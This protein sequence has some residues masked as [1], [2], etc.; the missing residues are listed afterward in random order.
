MVNITLQVSNLRRKKVPG[1]HCTGRRVGPRAIL[2]GSNTTKIFFLPEKKN[3]IP[4]C[5]ARSAVRIATALPSASVS[6]YITAVMHNV[7]R[8]V[9]SKTL[10]P[11]K[12]KMMDSVPN[13]RGQLAMYFPWRNRP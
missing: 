12:I 7:T 9:V 3:T 13:K 2:D 1:T 5:P 10:R 6:Q 11:Q 8:L 4:S